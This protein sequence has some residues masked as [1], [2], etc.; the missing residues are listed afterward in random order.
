MN[1]IHYSSTYSEIWGNPNLKPTSVYNL[2][3]MWQLNRRYTFVAFADFE[4]NFSAQLPYQPSDRFAV[5]MKE[6]NFNHR[7]SYGIQASAQFSAGQ[8]L[9]GNVFVVGQYVNDKCDDF[10]DM[11]FNRGKFTVVT[12]GTAS[13]LLCK[14]TNLR[15]VINP[16]FQSNA[17]QGVYNINNIFKLNAS[18]RWTSNND[19]WNVVLSGNNLTNSRFKTQ[20]KYGNQDFSMNVCQDWVTANLS[21]IFKFGNY[22]RKNIKEVDTSRMGY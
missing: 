16:F 14:K 20:S 17:I 18:L 7:N 6:V 1:S 15:F 11:P 10:F 4:P 21:I 2:S 3:L 12:G 8:W 13:L 9:N 19:K 22:K 5:I